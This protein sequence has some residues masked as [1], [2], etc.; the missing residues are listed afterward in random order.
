[1]LSINIDDFNKVINKLIENSQESVGELDKYINDTGKEATALA[2]QRSGLSDKH[3][4]IDWKSKG[5]MQGIVRNR[6]VSLW[7][8]AGTKERF[9]ETMGFAPTG[10]VSA[11]PF[12]ANAVY[13]VIKRRVEA[14]AEIV[15]QRLT[16]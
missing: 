8:D 9:R 7:T 4:L 15:A 3:S 16:K 5:L 11:R 14:L 2:K 10:S 1:M 6:Y 12:F 13:E